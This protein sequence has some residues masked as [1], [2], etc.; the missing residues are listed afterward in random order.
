MIYYS[1]GGGAAVGSLLR[2]EC[3]SGEVCGL[4]SSRAVRLP[5]Q[6]FSLRL[7]VSVAARNSSSFFA[8]VGLCPL[9][10]RM[11]DGTANSLLA[12]PLKGHGHALPD[13]SVFLVAHV[14]ALGPSRLG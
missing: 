12:R 7:S 6:R 4:A 11:N 2:E 10:T 3:L 8:L 14:V 5:F 13:A 1:C 9:H